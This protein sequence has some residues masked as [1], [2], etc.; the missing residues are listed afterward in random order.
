MSSL[1]ENSELVAYASGV[2]ES[3]NPQICINIDYEDKN[4]SENI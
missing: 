1:M 3:L 2:K 4:E